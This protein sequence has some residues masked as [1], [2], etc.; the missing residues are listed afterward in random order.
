[1]E[2]INI[3]I[4]IL[5]YFLG[6]FLIILGIVFFIIFFIDPVAYSPA[7]EIWPGSC[8]PCIISDNPF[9]YSG[10]IFLI[11]GIIILGF[12][13]Y[14]LKLPKIS[15]KKISIVLGLVGGIMSL[16]WTFFYIRYIT[17]HRTSPSYAIFGVNWPLLVIGI[18]TIIVVVIIVLG[19]QKH[20][21][22]L[23]IIIGI[24]SSFYLLFRSLSTS[25]LDKGVDLRGIT[26]T[27]LRI[28]Y[29]GVL[30]WNSFILIGGIIGYRG[31]YIEHKK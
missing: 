12:T 11:L 7:G 27:A 29:I 15:D 9:F 20:G 21:S 17:L 5:G 23:L 31:W 6:S 25:F 19:Y 24:L 10:L 22:I 3:N 18:L 30:I 16:I 14:E 2:K 1:M 26:N 13:H 28:I 4:K 8:P